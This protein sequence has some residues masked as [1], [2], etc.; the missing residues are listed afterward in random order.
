MKSIQIH[1]MNLNKQI[2]QQLVQLQESI[3]KKL[4]LQKKLL[5]KNCK[6]LIMNLLILLKIRNLTSKIINDTYI[7]YL[8]IQERYQQILYK[9]NNQCKLLDLNLILQIYSKDNI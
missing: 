7:L 4:Q 6:I 3:G 1:S 8:K 2:D 9:W 5:Y